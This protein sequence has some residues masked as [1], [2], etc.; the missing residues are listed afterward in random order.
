MD[1]ATFSSTLDGSNRDEILDEQLVRLFGEYQIAIAQNK[2]SRDRKKALAIELKPLCHEKWLTLR[3]QGKKDHGVKSWCKERGINRSKFYR[4]VGQYA[5]YKKL[6]GPRKGKADKSSA[7]TVSHETKLTDFPPD[8]TEMPI[9]I[10][11]LIVWANNTFCP[12]LDA[13]LE[14]M[15]IPERVVAMKTF[16]A[17]IQKKWFPDGY[18]AVSPKKPGGKK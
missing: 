8:H 12:L 6:D 3:A 17:P 15:S 16:L 4:L 13:I 18:V 10:A 2:E 5:T 7:P 14:P 9:D 1:I 11:T